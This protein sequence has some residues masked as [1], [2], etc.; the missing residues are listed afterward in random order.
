MQNWKYNINL[1][2]LWN[3][4]ETVDRA[5]PAVVQT[6]VSR[7]TD[8]IKSASFYKQFET[9][10]DEIIEHFKEDVTTIDDFDLVLND[11]Y[12]WA[13]TNRCWVKTFYGNS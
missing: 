11:F 5:D 8:R 6:L 10:L 1:V 12:D 2:D 7:M 13:D 3:W 4:M 9:D